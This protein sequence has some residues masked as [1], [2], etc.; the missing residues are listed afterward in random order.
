LQVS[1]FTEI[2]KKCLN[3]LQLQIEK[4]LPVHDASDCLAVLLDPATKNFSEWLLGRELFLETKNLL[5]TQHQE[6]YTALKKM[7]VPQ[8]NVE[9]E[10]LANNENEPT[11]N[12]AISLDLKDDEDPED[13]FD[14]SDED[15][16]GP[17]IVLP[18][19]QPKD[20]EVDLISEADKVFEK[21]MEF[22]PAF[23][24]YLVEGSETLV[25]NKTTGKVSF[26]EIVSKSDTKK[27]YRTGGLAAYP[28]CAG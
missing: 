21:W 7:S 25:S 8:V 10:V 11:E 9:S 28:H 20:G 4:R 6:A 19:E 26:R 12:M 15:I 14:D 27:Y 5:K 1:D 23:G 3:R 16:D 22:T 24:D 18:Q 2:G 13:L 17:S